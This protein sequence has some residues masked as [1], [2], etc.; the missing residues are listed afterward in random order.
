M[1]STYSQKRSTSPDNWFHFP[2]TISYPI[3]QKK[4]IILQKIYVLFD[5]NDSAK[6]NEIQIYNGSRQLK[7]FIELNQSGLHGNSPDDDNTFSLEEEVN[8]GIGISIKCNIY[9][10]TRS[11]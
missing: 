8:Q 10:S 7:K 9:K 11:W 6:I 5:S 1:G 3:D 2:I 4:K